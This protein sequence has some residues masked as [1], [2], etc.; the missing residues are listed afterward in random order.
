MEND[1]IYKEAKE[2]V[3]STLEI[4]PDE[5]NDETLFVDDLGCD[6]ILIIELKT[7]FEEKYNISIAKQDLEKLISLK[8]VV[9]YLTEREVT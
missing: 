9:N 8:D 6:S 1:K 3:C 7:Q 5:L 4:T 2:L